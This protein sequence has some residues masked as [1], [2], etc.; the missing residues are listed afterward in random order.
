[1]RPYEYP[2]RATVYPVTI[3][4]GGAP[5]FTVTAATDVQQDTVTKTV[6]CRFV[7]LSRLSYSDR[8]IDPSIS[9]R[10][11]ASPGVADGTVR[12]TAGAD[13]KMLEGSRIVLNG[14][15][16]RAGGIQDLQDICGHRTAV[17]IDLRGNALV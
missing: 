16:Y 5:K 9:G 6:P 10:M 2:H 4:T 1:M 8:M 12:D 13:V 15:T 14:K 3:Q 7:P 11:E 17:Q